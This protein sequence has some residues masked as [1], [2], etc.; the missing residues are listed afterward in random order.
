MR[1]VL[2]TCLT[3]LCL[4]GT[5]CFAQK[6]RTASG[7]YTYVIP[8]DQ[9]IS[10]AKQTALDQCKKI[11]LQNTFG[12]YIHSTEIA[13]TEDGADHYL[14]ESVSDVKGEW[15]ETIGEPKFTASVTN[16]QFLITVALT[17]K[18]REIV[19]AQTEINTHLARKYNNDYRQANTF[20]NG[21]YF[22]L[23]LQT[24]V[25]GYVV[26]YLTDATTATCLLPYPTLSLGSVPV[27][28]GIDYVFFARDKSYDELPVYSI[29]EYVAITYRKVEVN[30][31]HVL[32]S[33][34]P[35]A[36]A[37]GQKTDKLETIPI[38]DFQKWLARVRNQDPNMVV[39]ELSLT[40]EQSDH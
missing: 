18:I 40:I 36:K 8:E 13:H 1:N 4:F 23:T 38:R 25:P 32:F 9:T 24:P 7:S 33:T 5:A 14:Q 2:L 21:D 16:G 20:T 10:E 27:K 12:T 30:R 22:F 11:I 29:N 3:L 35:F 17:G 19:F 28:P 26:V 37:P 39:K 6:T 15:I 34:T 31:V